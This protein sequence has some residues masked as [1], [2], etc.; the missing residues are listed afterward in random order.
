M[1]EYVCMCV[2]CVR[3]DLSTWKHTYTNLFCVLF[4]FPLL[5]LMKG[6]EV[7]VCEPRG[8]HPFLVSVCLC[9]CIPVYTSIGMHN[10]GCVFLIM[11]FILPLL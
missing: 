8:R 11:L 2:G 1:Y 3:M 7:A 5:L 9:V 4:Y 10:H 6:L